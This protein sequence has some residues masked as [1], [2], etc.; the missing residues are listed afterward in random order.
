MCGEG[1]DVVGAPIVAALYVEPG[2]VY[3]NLPHV[4]PWGPERDARNYPG[5]LPV[6]AHPPCNRWSIWASCRD[7]RDGNDGG[8]FAAALDAVRRWGGVLEHPAHSLAWEVFGLPR[9]SRYGWTEALFDPGFT[10]EVDQA[11]YGLPHRKPTWLYAVGCGTP[12]MIW[13]QPSA[14]VPP[15]RDWWETG[16]K[17]S[18]SRTPVAMRDALLALARGGRPA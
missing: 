15:L 5:P 6:V 18:R 3:Y 8:C 14:E 4:D 10:T 9:P 2:G 1:A 11:M 16:A 7:T 13:L 17:S 12:P